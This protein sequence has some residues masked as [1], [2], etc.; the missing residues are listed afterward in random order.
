M[1][2]ICSSYVQLPSEDHPLSISQEY[3]YPPQLEVVSIVRN[4]TTRRAVAKRSPLNTE[5]T[6]EIITISGSG[7][8][9]LSEKLKITVLM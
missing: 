6:A 8:F 5:M 4:S 7:F 2:N 1:A 9:F 3:S